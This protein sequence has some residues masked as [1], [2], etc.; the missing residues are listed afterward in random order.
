AGYVNS[1]DRPGYEIDARAGHSGISYDGTAELLAFSTTFIGVHA[2][3]DDVMFASD[4]TFQGVNLHDQLNH[5]TN[6][7]G[8]R[9]R[10][11][12]TPLTAIIVEGAQQQERFDVD[13]LR[14][15]DSSQLTVSVRFDPA[16]LLK[17]TATV[18]Y[19]DYR[20]VAGAVER[21]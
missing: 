12:A 6:I 21:F 2:A 5:K 13:R 8:V 3:H 10:Y 17:G 20:P 4:A 7:E 16:A 11:Q 18:G 14:D 1:R 9:V 15:A 19:R